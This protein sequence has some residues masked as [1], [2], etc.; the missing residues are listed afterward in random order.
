MT[1]APTGTVRVEGVTRTFRILRERNQTLKETL[2]RRGRARYTEFRALRDVSLEIRP[3]ESVGLVGRN[4]AGKSTLLKLIAGIMEPTS[5]RIVTAGTIASMLELGAGFHPDF[6]GRE[7][8]FLNAA[9]LG[10]GEREVRDRFDEIVEFAELEDFIDSP[11][12]TYSSGMQ[13]RL[14]FAVASHVRADI[15]LLDEVFAVGD[16][17]FQR[18]CMGRMF[19][20]RRAG[21]TLVFVSHD[22]SAVERICDRAVLM[23]AGRVLDDGDPLDVLAHYHRVLASETRRA[24]VVDRD[25]EAAAPRAPDGDT[26]EGDPSR[27]GNRDVEIT[28]VRLLDGAGAATDSFGSGDALTI[29]MDFEI[30]RPVPFPNFG[31]A[32]HSVEGVAC[33]GTNMAREGWDVPASVERGAV[34]FVIPVLHLHEGRFSVTVAATSHDEREVYDWRDRCREFS[35]FAQGRGVGLVD[36]GGSW[37]LRSGVGTSG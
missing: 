14:A 24:V 17:A 35:V 4:G 19:D 26:A 1:G 15:M 37:E 2:L 18:K 10:F 11:V 36:L 7:N 30:H 21:G 31:I 23:E 27:W 5:G 6:S 20:F 13:L 8:L 22:P 29:E 34:R 12:R 16:E 3:G 25:T 28:A 32:V 33:Y 9:I